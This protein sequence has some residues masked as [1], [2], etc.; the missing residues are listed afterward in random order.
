MRESASFDLA[1]PLPPPSA[2]A[3]FLAN[4]TCGTKGAP[5]CPRRSERVLAIESLPMAESLY[6]Y[7]A[8][9]SQDAA[10]RLRHELEQRGHVC[11]ARWI[12][13]ANFGR[14]ADEQA[15]M[16]AAVMD[17]EDVS[18]AK[19]GLILLSENEGVM[20]PGGK[21]VEMGFALAKGYPVYVIGRLE[22]TLQYHPSVTGYAT[23]EAFLASLGMVATEPASLATLPSDL[24]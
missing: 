3:L 2:A 18:A 19:D 24:S 20:V 5:K 14:R 6:V 11:T 12:L 4:P 17:L 16:E 7:I 1:V 21:H 13:D 22:N 9:S 10:K 23:V 15:K 8:A